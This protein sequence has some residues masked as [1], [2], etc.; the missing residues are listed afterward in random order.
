MHHSSPVLPVKEKNSN[1][2]FSKTEPNSPPRGNGKHVQFALP[3]TS[4]S[5]DLLVVHEEDDEDDKPAKTKKTVMK[6]TKGIFS[7]LLGKKDTS[8]DTNKFVY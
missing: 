5:D 4:A 8:P 7:K 2:V 6:T 1:S 3:T